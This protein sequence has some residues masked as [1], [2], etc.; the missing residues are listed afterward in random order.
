MMFTQYVV[1]VLDVR[2]FLLIDV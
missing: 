2:H 1:L